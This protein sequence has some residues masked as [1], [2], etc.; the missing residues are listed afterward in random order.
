MGNRDGLGSGS[1]RW[2]ESYPE[3]QV[4]RHPAP[5]ML[6]EHCPESRWVRA[7]TAQASALVSG[8]APE[9]AFA[10]RIPAVSSLPVMSCPS[11]ETGR[12]E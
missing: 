4:M 7:G 11:I 5:K 9:N 2:R 12:G 10:K 3:V 8:T 1:K 6:S